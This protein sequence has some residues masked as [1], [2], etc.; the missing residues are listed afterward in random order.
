MID[1]S[2]WPE[3]AK[4]VFRLIL[5]ELEKKENELVFLRRELR[6][7]AQSNKDWEDAEFVLVTKENTP[8]RKT[9]GAML[10]SES[11]KGKS[12]GSIGELIDDL[13]S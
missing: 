10:E 2:G 5:R 11:G 12:F 4:R 7:W 1:M 3:S 8:N 13:N 9:R 6:H